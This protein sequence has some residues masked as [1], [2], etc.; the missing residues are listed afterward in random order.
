ML[1]EMLTGKLPFDSDNTVSVALMQ[2]Q[3]DPVKP[4]ELNSEIPVG[5]EQIVLKAM[6]KNVHDRYQSAAEMLLDLEEFK[7]NPSV[8][9]DYTYTNNEPT[10][11]IPVVKSERNNSVDISANDNNEPVVKNRTIPILVGI[12]VA[13]VVVL[14][15]VFGILYSKGYF[16]GN[17]K[18]KVPDFKG[19]IYSEESFKE[20]Y[21]DFTFEITEKVDSSVTPDSV[22]SQDPEAGTKIVPNKVVINLVI[23][24]DSE[25]IEVPTGLIGEDY[26]N[27]VTQLTQAGFQVKEKEAKSEDYPDIPAGTVISVSPSESTK[28]SVGS[29]VTIEYVSYDGNVEKLV[30]VP[31][32]SGLTENGAKQALTSLGFNVKI[33]SEYNDTVKLGYV[34][35]NTFSGSK[36]PYGS[37]VTVTI[38]KGAKIEQ[39][40]SVEVTLPNTGEY[41]L[42][43]A[44]LDSEEIFSQSI[45]LD[46]SKYNFDVSSAEANS[47]F[48]VF[49]DGNIIFKCN[50]NFAATPVLITNQ[51]YFDMPT[52]EVPNVLGHTEAEAKKILSDSGFE[53]VTTKYETSSDEATKG[54]VIKQTPNFGIKASSD[55][56]IV[57]TIG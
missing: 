40:T 11:Y 44:T 16:T 12:I 15:S 49:A 26:V 34:V 32:V 39:T 28:V 19:Q 30:P 2:L 25:L 18:V 13:L 51:S 56:E 21:P 27:V 50:I 37:T 29:V 42:V 33:A 9:F 22:I 38:S 43:T 48:R 20:K 41:A 10:K 3:K 54:K 7:R 24:T 31:D 4:R 36:I 8:K 1:Y 23:A 5:L 55:E 45:Y 35:S 57:I 52:T 6:Q 47:V 53:N 14:G 46:G 17:V